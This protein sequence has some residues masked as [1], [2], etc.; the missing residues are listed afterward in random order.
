MSLVTKT[1]GKRV[2]Q[3]AN[4]YRL[5]SRWFEAQISGCGGPPQENH[6]LRSGIKPNP[7]IISNP[8]QSP[9]TKGGRVKKHTPLQK[10]EEKENYP[11]FLKGDRGDFDLKE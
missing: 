5:K 4:F 11:P 6:R 10:G 7:T 9:F 8:P 2:T 1:P 3:G